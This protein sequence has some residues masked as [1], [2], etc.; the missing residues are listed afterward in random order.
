MEIDLLFRD[1]VS[2]RIGR[3]KFEMWFSSQVHFDVQP[4]RILLSVPNEFFGKWIRDH[5]RHVI[6]QVSRQLLGK[7]YS[8]DVHVT[9]A[10]PASPLSL[11]PATPLLAPTE[12]SSLSTG[13]SEKDSETFAVSM[14]AS[15]INMESEP[16]DQREAP[17]LPP[18]SSSSPEIGRAHV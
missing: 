8:L 1:A 5:Y 14:T 15:S 4:D 17:S 12:E 7:D 10:S 11:N 13:T 18:A 9:G 6:L 16:V 3:R 2:E